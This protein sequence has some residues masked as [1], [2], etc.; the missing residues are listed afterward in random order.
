[1]TDHDSVN[2]PSH[3]TQYKGI[4]VIQLTEQMN[5][6]RGNAV[7]YIARAGFKDSEV[8]IVD[9]EKAKWYIEREIERIKKN[10]EE[11]V[12]QEAPSS[13]YTIYDPRGEIVMTSSEEE[14]VRWLDYVDA[15]DYY[16]VRLPDDS[17]RLGKFFVAD[18]FEKERR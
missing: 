15:R 17:W 16:W 2:H 4:E 13:E 1:M 18:Y 8:E 6:N 12:Q 7:K 9:L 14:V 10:G 11:V 3:Y 5:F